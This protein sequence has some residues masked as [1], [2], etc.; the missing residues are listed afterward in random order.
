MRNVEGEGEGRRDE[1]RGGEG[2][3]EVYGSDHLHFASVQ[4]DGIFIR[5]KILMQTFDTQRLI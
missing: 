2:G 4:A 5:H 3:V 1:G